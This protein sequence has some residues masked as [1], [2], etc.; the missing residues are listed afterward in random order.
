MNVHSLLYIQ[1][2]LWVGILR[3]PEI[4]KA[5]N[6]QATLSRSSH[7]KLFSV[8]V[9]CFPYLHTFPALTRH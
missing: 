2:M 8:S 4:Y 6:L 5:H 7:A 9:R 3:L 1:S